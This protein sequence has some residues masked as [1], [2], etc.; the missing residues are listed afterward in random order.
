MPQ[1]N[2]LFS[3]YAEQA[4][5]SSPHSASGFDP[6]DVLFFAEDTFWRPI[7]NTDGNYLI[8]DREVVSNFDTVGFLGESLD[9]MGVVILGSSDADFTT[10]PN[11]L[12]SADALT[13]GDFTTGGASGSP[14]SQA[15]GSLWS[16][17]TAG[18][19]SIDG[20]QTS[21]DKLTQSGSLTSTV[22]YMIAAKVTVDSSNTGN[23]YL[24]AGTNRSSAINTSGISIRQVTANGT[25]FSLVA[26]STSAGDFSGTVDWVVAVPVSTL[27]SSVNAAYT[28]LTGAASDEH[29]MVT[30]SN[31]STLMHVAHI[32]FSE[33]LILPSFST[34]WDKYNANPEAINLVSG[35]GR[36]EGSVVDF[37][38]RDFNFQWPGIPISE[39]VKI[40]NLIT[41]GQKAIERMLPF[42]FIPD[43]TDDTESYF[44]WP[45]EKQKWG[46][47]I[48]QQTHRMPK[49]VRAFT[50]AI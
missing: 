5:A 45:D 19:A 40:N 32:A 43:I 20:S 16:F 24:E 26:D 46:F 3:E 42:I 8:V 14:W 48:E 29:V 49:R 1:P 33:A 11:A 31:Y 37:T 27:S 10:L 2:F 13:D 15:S 23:L 12:N 35:A 4:S 38:L 28:S 9:G 47:P 25:D 18:G 30:F 6:S 36:Y 21:E 22:V 44:C 41:F 7:D 50:R 39:T 34:D 17:P